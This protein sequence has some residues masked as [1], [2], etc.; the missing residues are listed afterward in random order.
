MHLNAKSQHLQLYSSEQGIGS[1][2]CTAGKGLAPGFSVIPSGAL[3][4]TVH[5]LRD[6]GVMLALEGWRLHEIL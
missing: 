1:P 2:D 3:S 5:F 6:S 4:A